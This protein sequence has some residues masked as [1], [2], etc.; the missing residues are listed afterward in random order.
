MRLSASEQN[1]QGEKYLQMILH[2]LVLDAAQDRNDCQAFSHKLV[3]IKF[4]VLLLQTNQIIQINL[5]EI[6][7]PS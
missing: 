1:W 7:F 4:Q 3:I 6:D 5:Q 2:V